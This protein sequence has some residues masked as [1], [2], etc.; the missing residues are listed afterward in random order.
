LICTEELDNVQVGAGLT[1][2]A[3]AQ[4]KFT[5][6]PKEPVDSSA[7]VKLAVDPGFIVWETGEPEAAPKLKFGGAVAT[8]DKATVCGL[9]GALSLIIRFAVREPAAV[10]VKVTLTTQLPPAD[11]ELPHLLVW[12]KSELFAPVMLVSVMFSVAFPLFASVIADGL[13]LVPTCSGEKFCRAGYVVRK[14]PFTPLPFTGIAKGLIGVLSVSV[15]VPDCEPTIVGEYVTV[16]AQLAPGLKLV[17]Q[18]LVSAK[19]PE[20]AKL[21]ISTLTLLGLL[22]VMIFGA[23]VVPTPCEPK[24]SELGEIAWNETLSITA[25]LSLTPDPGIAQSGAPSP[26]KSPTVIAF[27]P[28]R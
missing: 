22:T 6:P 4:L 26:L 21:D 17:P 25:T 3:I 15:I 18:S 9:P 16:T 12:E 14:A 10:G 7:I 20:A 24:L 2:G 27:P 19:F 11:N 8:P 1:T 28:R 23:L 5:V 13:L